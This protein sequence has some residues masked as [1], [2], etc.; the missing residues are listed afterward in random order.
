[1]K[2]LIA[3]NE[4]KR[5]V[6]ALDDLGIKHDK[7]QDANSAASM[8]RVKRYDLFLLDVVL[9]GISGVE[10][11]RTLRY[12]SSAPVILVGS[13]C[14]EAEIVSAFDA[15]ADDYVPSQFGILELEGRIRAVL[16]RCGHS[17]ITVLDWLDITTRAATIDGCDIPL[18]VIEFDLLVALASAGGA[19]SKQALIREVWGSSAYATPDALKV[20][21]HALRSKIGKTR[22]ET[23]RGYGYRLVTK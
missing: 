12:K 20:R 7:A 23:V 11:C 19:I 9:P 2:A 14:S 10:F 16:R 6:R 5:C 4:Y 1:M 18:S 3:S 22:I 8:C 15:G 21:I 17:R 13:Q